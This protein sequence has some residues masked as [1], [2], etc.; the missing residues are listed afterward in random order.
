M[1]K[2]EIELD[3]QTYQ[4]VRRHASASGRTLSA[5]LQHMLRAIF[6]IGEKQ[7]VN[8]LSDF[9][10]IGAGRSDQGGRG[11]EDHDIVLGETRW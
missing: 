7:P 11:S 6:G 10:F 4:A 8:S 1:P 3:D 5:T 9:T 2:V